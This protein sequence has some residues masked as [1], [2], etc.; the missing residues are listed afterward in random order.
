MEGAERAY[1]CRDTIASS[2]LILFFTLGISYRQKPNIPVI[3]EEYLQISR[4]RLVV[5]SRS[6]A[7]AMPKQ[8]EFFSAAFLIR[9]APIRDTDSSTSFFLLTQ[10]ISLLIFH[11]FM[12]AISLR[13]LPTPFL[14]KYFIGFFFCSAKA[15]VLYERPLPLHQ[16]FSNMPL[17]FN[18]VDIDAI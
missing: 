3:V 16:I 6:A 12:A 4:R 8:E 2:F 9:T 13:A 14:Q 18:I 1:I 5:T 15:V 7:R 17:R 11:L 10:H